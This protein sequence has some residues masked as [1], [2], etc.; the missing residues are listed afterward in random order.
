MLRFHRSMLLRLWNN[1][2]SERL[3]IN[4][5]FHWL[6]YPF[7]PSN[8]AGLLC[9]E[10]AIN[11]ILLRSML[12]VCFVAN[13]FAKKTIGNH[14]SFVPNIVWEFT[15]KFD[16]TRWSGGLASILTWHYMFVF[17]FT[18]KTHKYKETFWNLEQLRLQ[19]LSIR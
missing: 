1:S 3:L 9:I 15:W 6:G 11:E 4:I 13:M 19:N 16:W 17:L 12:I 5:Y 7:Q 2:Q 10:M 14:L 8:D 18:F